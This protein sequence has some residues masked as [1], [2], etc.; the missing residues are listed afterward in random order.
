MPLEAGLLEI[1]ACPACHAPLREEQSGEAS[2]LV[3]TGEGC[4]LAY[5]VRDGIP[6]LLVDEARRPA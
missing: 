6:V 2:E 5:P 1:L 4:G 3:C